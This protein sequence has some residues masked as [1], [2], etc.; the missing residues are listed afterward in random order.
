[1]V[2][3]MKATST[4]FMEEIQTFS[5]LCPTSSGPVA[6]SAMKRTSV[7]N[8]LEKGRSCSS[9]KLSMKSSISCAV[10]RDAPVS[11]R[12]FSSVLT[13]EWVYWHF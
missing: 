9:M 11:L 4:E 8:H 1:M 12:N 7:P 3:Q 2:T 5:A 10:F 13:L 6:S